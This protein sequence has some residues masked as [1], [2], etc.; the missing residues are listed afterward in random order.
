MPTIYLEGYSVIWEM[1]DEA[2]Q[3]SDGSH[4]ESKEVVTPDLTEVIGC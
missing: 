1:W 3:I 2:I 4:L